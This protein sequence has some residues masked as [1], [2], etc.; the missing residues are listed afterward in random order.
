MSV[1][2]DPPI[3]LYLEPDEEITSVVRRV[4]AADAGRIVLVAPG[5]AKATASAT[6]L[7]LLARVAADEGREVAIVGDA[8]TRSLAAEAELTAYGSVDDARVAKAT[9]P[10]PP[11]R[12][13]IHVLRGEDATA[14]HGAAEHAATEDATA[15]HPAA[16]PHHAT[17]PRPAAAPVPTGRGDETRAIPV[18]RPSRPVPRPTP[19]RRPLAS[20]RPA[21][22]IGIGVVVLALLLVGG[23]AAA[24]LPAATVA[25]Q[26]I[27][28][29]IPTR[30]YELVFA[31]PSVSAG[32]VDASVDGTATGTYHDLIPAAGGVVFFNWSF[33]D[34]A[35]PAGTPI[36]A[37]D[38][39]F[40]TG[41]QVVVP[42][43]SLISFN[44]PTI[45]AGEAGAS[46][47]AVE[48]GEA[49]NVGAGA[50]NAV[51]DENVAA[52]LRGLPDNRERLVTNPEA[53]AGG[54]DETGIEIV[55]ADVD[56]AVAELRDTLAAGVAEALEGVEGIGVD[57]PAE[58]TITIPD[59]LVGTRDQESFTLTGE[60]AYER[61]TV[62]SSEIE[63][64]ARQ[65]L[66]EDA[67]AIP[68]GHEIL[69]DS[70]VVDVVE[71]RRQDGSLVVQVAVNGSSAPTIVED[72]VRQ[73]IAGEKVTDAQI[74]LEALG[75][76]TIT[77]WPGWVDAI[78][79]LDWRVEIRINAP[80]A[81]TPSPTGDL[82]SI[83]PSP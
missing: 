17:A 62:A 83:A 59:G 58:P 36:G 19:R 80:D 29:P 14:A 33:Q 79:T 22:I 32:T 55:Q 65:R 75:D 12:A 63:D 13:A 69:A 60:L 54:L 3:L 35:V 67:E 47:A 42:A 66:A 41:E 10:V 11:Q 31:Q 48:P 5:R 71:S 2:A 34:V 26:P 25:I 18:A 52:Q 53:M 40:A 8:L 39:V 37:G 76:V 6:S 74:E 1:T 56:A 77:T 72:E 21:T 46:A 28:T 20:R 24:V 38:T 27:G 57:T 7:R 81:A 9:A 43:G 61:V 68:A 73:M 30:E 64:L 78:P 45:Q 23:A 15:P 49:G 82:S 70:V 51:L 50:I 16:V 4:R 44:P